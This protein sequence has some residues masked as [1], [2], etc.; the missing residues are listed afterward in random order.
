MSTEYCSWDRAIDENWYHLLVLKDTYPVDL[1]K[2][3][4]SFIPVEE[5]KKEDFNFF[6]EYAL[7]NNNENGYNIV[8]EKVIG[9]ETGAILFYTGNEMEKE[10]RDMRERIKRKLKK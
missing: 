3:I 1:I 8:L 9:C 2:N 7:G 6:K 4:E 10:I 5:I